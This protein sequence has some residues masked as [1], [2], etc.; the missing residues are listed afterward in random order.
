M[1]LLLFTASKALLVYDLA[2]TVWTAW[3]L[4]PLVR[5][6]RAVDPVRPL[7]TD[8]PP[9]FT[10]G[11]CV[12]MGEAV[13]RVRGHY[14]YLSGWLYYVDIYVYGRGWIEPPPG[15]YGGYPVSLDGA[16]KISCPG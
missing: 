13:L 11:D 10:F 1:A 4:P 16:V 7:R 9:P 14:T 3:I 5:S 6:E 8:A 15:S 2:R 12:Q